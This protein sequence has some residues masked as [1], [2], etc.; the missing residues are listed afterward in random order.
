MS[1]NGRSIPEYTRFVKYSRL[2]GLIQSITKINGNTKLMFSN[3]CI[4]LFSRQ[5]LRESQCIRAILRPGNVNMAPSRPHDM[6]IQNFT[7]IFD[8]GPLCQDEY[9]N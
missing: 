1:Y 8:A 2:I 7:M 4:N 6:A 5:Y 3:N 9:S